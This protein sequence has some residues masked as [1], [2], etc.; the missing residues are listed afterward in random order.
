[1]RTSPSFSQAV[2]TSPGEWV[3]YSSPMDRLSR[4]NQLAD[5]ARDARIFPGGDHATG[6]CG[7]CARIIADRFGGKVVGYWHE[8]ILRQELEK[9]RAAMISR[10]RAMISRPPIQTSTW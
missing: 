4:K 9:P 6:S 3:C 5:F 1:M 7:A 10:S 8:V 2:I